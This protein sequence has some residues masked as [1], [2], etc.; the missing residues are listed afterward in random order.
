MVPE[1]FISNAGGTLK[2]PLV[3][4]LARAKEELSLKADEAEVTASNTQP[5]CG[6]EPVGVPQ[7]KNMKG[8]F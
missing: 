4:G 8:K 6:R 2:S 5:C 1:R 7:R 3:Q